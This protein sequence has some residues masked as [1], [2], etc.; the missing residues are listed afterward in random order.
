MP[1]MRLRQLD[2]SG[3]TYNAS[4]PFT[5]TKKEQKKLKKQVI[6][7]IFVKKK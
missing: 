3:F 5:K 4:G 7:D 1:E 6:H 2:Q